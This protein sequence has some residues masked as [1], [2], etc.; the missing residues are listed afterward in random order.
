[1]LAVCSKN[2]LEDAQAPFREKGGMVLGLDDFAVFK[3]NWDDK[4]ENLRRI[5]AEIGVGLDSL[6]VI[7]D[8]PFERAWIRSQLPQV[9]VP[10]LGASVFTY[11]RDLDRGRYFP[12]ITWSP[13]DRLRAEGY[14]REQERAS[15]RENAGNLE[16]FLAGL[17]MRGTCEPV[18]DANIERV[19]QL[20][21][22]TNQFNLTTRRRTLAEV[23][24][25]ASAPGLD[26]RVQPAGSLRRL[27]HHRPAVLRAR[28]RARVLGD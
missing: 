12:A 21:N 17:H 16:D 3:A 19:T 13:E 2:N 27:R 11:A 18:S 7:D 24:H 22:K 14:R 8:N 23:R 26:R 4:A 5:A 15:A 10:E 6:V 20:T 28:R 9:A 1:M 25:L